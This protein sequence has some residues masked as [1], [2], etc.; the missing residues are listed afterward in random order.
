[1]TLLVY[2]VIL[3]VTTLTFG[4]PFAGPSFTD[5]PYYFTLAA[6]NTTLP[7][8][9]KTGVPLVLGQNGASSLV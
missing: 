6:W 2:F 4:S 1:M 5:L 3:A 8:A 9:N 7:N